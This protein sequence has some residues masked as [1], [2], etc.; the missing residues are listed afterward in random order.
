MTKKLISRFST[1][2]SNRF[3]EVFFDA[4][5]GNYICY[6]YYE[7]GYISH[8]ESFPDISVRRVEDVALKWL[9]DVVDTFKDI[10]CERFDY[11]IAQTKTQAVR[12]RKV[13]KF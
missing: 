6:F 4:E 3:S 9:K 10:H 7:D 1:N 5:I 13:L 8:T 12:Y 2:L 11:V